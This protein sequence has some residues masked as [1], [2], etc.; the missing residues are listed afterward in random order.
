MANVILFWRT[1]MY[2]NLVIEQLC[3]LSC[4]FYTVMLESVKNKVP[5]LIAIFSKFQANYY[6]AKNV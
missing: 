5:L 2:F 3:C 1:Q 6:L 4:C